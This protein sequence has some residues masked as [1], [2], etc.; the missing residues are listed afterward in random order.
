ME[1]ALNMGAFEALDQQEMF[2]VDGGM[3]GLEIG[4]SVSGIYAGVVGGMSI[5]GT[6]TLACAATCAA[7]AAT[8]VVAI[9]AGICGV[10]AAGYGIYSLGK[11]AWDS[12]R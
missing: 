1:M 2:A 11:L 3:N 6:T 9:T 10:V 5:L 7:I 4:I 12:L 8:P